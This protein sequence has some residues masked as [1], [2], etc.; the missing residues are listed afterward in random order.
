MRW[1]TRFQS[2]TE[3]GRNYSS[4]VMSKFEVLHNVFSDDDIRLIM[5]FWKRKRIGHYN[6]DNNWDTLS[7]DITHVD[8]PHRRVDIVG[9][10]INEIPIITDKIINSFQSN[11]LEGPHY[12]TKYPTGG[13]HSLHTDY[14]VHN[15]I[16]RTKV[17]TVQLSD[18][19]DYEGGLLVIDNEVAP[20]NK[21][22]VILYNGNDLH[23]VTKVTNGARFSL[24]ECTGIPK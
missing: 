20:K 1:E 7:N 10:P 21:G 19:S 22:S 17:I 5:E 16:E 13:L 9:L 11:H 6:Y 3:L 24:T 8:T 14:G 18:P 2:Q 4:N 12:L 23:E 15:G